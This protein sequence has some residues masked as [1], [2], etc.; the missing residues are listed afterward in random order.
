MSSG[1]DPLRG[2]A[3]HFTRGNDPAAASEARNRGPSDDGLAAFLHWLTE[4]DDTGFRASLSILWYGYVRPTSYALGIAAGVPEVE[5][6]QCSAC[7]SATRLDKLK[8]LIATRSLYGVGFRQDLLYG[9][10][11]RPVRYLAS[12]SEQVKSLQTDISERQKAGVNP[13]D[14]LWKKTPFIDGSKENAREEEWRVPRGFS[15]EPDDVAFA[16]IPEDLHDNARAFFEEHRGANTGPAYL[17]RYID[18]RWDR[19][20]IEQVLAAPAPPNRRPHLRSCSRTSTRSCASGPP[21][22]LGVARLAP[23]PDALDAA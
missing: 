10:G 3:V 18:P 23:T 21:R 9:A 2:Y 6:T 15:F 13:R 5:A 22:R 7:F 19:A 20:R 17:C 12:G 1:S 11:G 8:H 14:E 16:F 4:I